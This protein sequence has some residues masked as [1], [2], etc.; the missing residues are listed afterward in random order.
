MG[1]SFRSI[2]Q[3]GND[4]KSQDSPTASTGIPPVTPGEATN[5]AS[6][7]QNFQ[8]SSPQPSPFS[9]GIAL[10]KT[11]TGESLQASPVQP[12]PFSAA[13][14]TQSSTPLTVADVLPQLP[15]EI[16]RSNGLSPDQ[17]VA[18]SPQV[19]DAALRSGHAALPIFEIYRVCPALFQSPIS[20]QDPRMVPLP[21]SKLPRLIASAQQSAPAAAGPSPAASPFGT[22]QPSAGSFTPPT[23][24]ENP[25]MTTLPPRR[26]GPPPSLA[27]V[28][29]GDVSPSLS[30]PT[31]TAPSV[32]PASP[33]AAASAPPPPPQGASASPFGFKPATPPPVEPAST[34]PFG[35]KP[36]M[37]QSAEPSAPSS[38]LFA[39]AGN[40]VQPPANSIAFGGQG[41][42][43]ASPFA[44]FGASAPAPATPA[45]P[46]P[47]VSPFSSLF[48]PKA[49][50]TGQ[51]APDAPA[52]PAFAVAASTPPPPP[53]TAGGSNL[54][55]SLA[56]LLRGYSVAE[57][58]FDPIM[59]PSWIMTSFPASVVRDWAQQPTPLAEL[60]T[61]VDG[62]TDVGFRNVLNQA[63]RDFQVRIPSEE[64]QSVLT[65]GTPS[66]S[67]PNLSS[68]GAAPNVAASAPES[69]PPKTIPLFSAPSAPVQEA[70]PQVQP[71]PLFTAPSQSVPLF[72]TGSAQPTQPLGGF[73]A[74]PPAASFGSEPPAFGFH[75]TQAP[76]HNPFAAPVES[77]STV[78]TPP[79]VPQ[80]LAP[81]SQAWT[82]Q[83]PEAEESPAKSLQAALSSAFEVEEKPAPKPQAAFS[84]APA[85]GFSSAQLLGSV[86]AE[87]F[88][89]V[90]SIPVTNPF[91]GKAATHVVD[92][93]D[94]SDVPAAFIPPK[95]GFADDAFGAPPVKPTS[96]FKPPVFEDEPMSAAPQAPYT[97][98]PAPRS[99]SP[100]SALGIKSHDGNP[101]QILLR[102][103]LS[104]DEELSPKHVV[105]M[106]CSLPGIAACV[107]I[108]GDKSISHVGAHKPQAREFQR[109]ATDLA[110]HLRTLAPLIGIEGA[111]TF[112]LNSGDR[113]MTF[114]F[115]EGAILGV[116]HDA[117]PS[118]GL[119]DKIT[120][121]AREL[122]RM[123]D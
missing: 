76:V 36:S 91:T 52:R 15:P 11:A 16:V 61:L 49:V 110:H 99:T 21:A 53:A 51:P 28:P 64:I 62:V 72:N 60:G 47:S 79:P 27:D 122:S 88:A 102:A 4:S 75:P 94:E 74:V 12:S 116:L 14:T 73:G 18:I 81:P 80:P 55:F 48:G 20:P 1:F 39:P 44:T 38:G 3:T 106:V 101:D 98:R 19:L 23:P 69:E 9:T 100:S 43:P 8:P 97:P 87:A 46:T 29:R 26:N 71:S 5:P 78:P 30:L 115:P 41:S 33:F 59:V 93:P 66:Q 70:P 45:A 120:L 40:P 83:P 7:M 65:G 117:E 63:K 85:D 111:E 58:G 6:A 17:P 25:G 89:P 37:P 118:L 105:E 35:F 119:R 2:F 108:H 22:F 54:R 68:L 67:L 109:Q 95:T 107:C 77:Q 56:S 31:G 50:P 42:T 114:C 32:F 34:S 84:E 96:S 82:V 13:A 123:L 57:L 104:T 112:T 92:V 86:A 24:S 90:P 113:L 103:L 121:I 10:F